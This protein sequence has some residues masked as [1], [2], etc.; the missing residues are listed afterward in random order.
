MVDPRVS[1]LLIM[2]AF[3]AA[4]GHI[5]ARITGRTQVAFWLKP[6]PI[7]L[8]LLL[9]LLVQEVN[10]GSYR[11]FVA[12]ALVASMAGDILLALPRDAF[13]PGLASFL[14]AHVFYILAFLSIPLVRGFDGTWWLLL[15]IAAYGGALLLLLWPGVTGLLRFAVLAYTGVILLML[16]LAGALWLGGATRSAFVA[17]LFFVTS[18]SVLALTKFRARFGGDDAV[19]MVTYYTAQMLFALSVLDW[20]TCCG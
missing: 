15:P 17:A 9:V 12:L 16:W 3:A 7:L 2:V 1:S 20:Y 19:V 5:W 4:A 18:D 10:P 11:L 13:L 6:V 14:I 8:A